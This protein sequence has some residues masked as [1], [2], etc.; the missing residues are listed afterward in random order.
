MTRYYLYCVPV[1]T[2]GKLT[3]FYLYCVPVNTRGKLTR[4]Y[5][6]CVPVNTRGKL[7]ISR[8]QAP[9]D[10]TKDLKIGISYF[11]TKHA[12]LRRKSKDWLAWNQDNVAE[13]DGMSICRLFFSLS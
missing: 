9:I 11:S 4:F 3:R 8:V 1:N 13:W 2:R 6:Y 12:A 5:L 10:Q 7:T